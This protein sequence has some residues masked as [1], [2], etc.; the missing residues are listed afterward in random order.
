[1]AN[2]IKLTKIA[3][4]QFSDETEFYEEG[5]LSLPLL[6]A[7]VER[8]EMIKI[9]YLDTDENEQILEADKLLAR[10]I[11]H[12]YDHLIGKMIPDRVSPEIKKKLQAELMRIMK[13]EIDISYPITDRK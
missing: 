3:I 6:T 1:M 11:Q 2:K 7:D 8:P 12:E 10:V 13:R 4:I 9:K 5:C